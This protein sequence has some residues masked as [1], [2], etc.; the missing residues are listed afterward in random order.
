MKYFTKEELACKHCLKEGRSIDEAYQFSD[1]FATLLDQIREECGFP[2][3]VASG[4]RCSNHPIEAAKDSVGE[5]TTGFAVDLAVSYGN[6]FVLMQVAMRHGIHR[7][8]I[9][10]KGSLD[11]R[12][13]HLGMAPRFPSPAI[14]SY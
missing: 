9:N 6:A 7:I 8:G 1:E 14:W 3:P 12:F 13:I 5:H 2:L 10:Q 11:A 4:Y